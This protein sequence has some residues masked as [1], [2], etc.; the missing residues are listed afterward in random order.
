MR[1]GKRSCQARVNREMKI[2]FAPQS[3]TSYSG[4]ELLDRFLR[5]VD[6]DGR[7]RRA[8]A[9]QR[10]CGDYSLTS[11]IRLLLGLLWVGGRRLSHVDY[12]RGDLLVCRLA[13][14]RLLP[15]ERTLSRWLKQFTY[16]SV[17]V[18]AEL[19]TQL[20]SETLRKLR[21]RRVTLDVDGSIVSTGL[22][23][24]WAKRGF[25]PHH[26]KVPSYYPILAH[27]A[28]T[29]QILAVKNR[30]GNVHDGK[31]SE[32]FIR[33]VLRQARR[34]L[35]AAV[36]FEFRLDGAFFQR[37]VLEELARRDVEYAVKVPMFPWLDLRAVVRR[38]RRWRRVNAEIS[39]FVTRIPLNCWETDLPLVV[40][41]RRV[42]HETRK[43]FQ[44]DLFHPDDGHYEYSAVTTNKQIGAVALWHFMAGRGAPREDARRTQR[45]FRLRLRPDQPLCGEQRL[46]AAVRPRHES[47]ALLPDGDHRSSTLPHAQENLPLRAGVHQDSQIHVAQRRRAPRRAQRNPHAPPERHHGSPQ[48]LRGL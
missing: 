5:M 11:M 31:R 7:V 25:N 14:L 17:R 6:L 27:V 13:R 15:H 41:R 26:R 28:Q 20:V 29:G 44:L 3:L 10:V 36:T 38:C 47:L 37:P 30:P 48:A 24:A 19:N 46:A 22:Q 40:Y 21:L 16:R 1:L 45:R 35:G 43:N 39:Y 34:E 4:L 18:L 23:V 42:N 2:E 8:F 32:Y 12:V 9:E 33:D